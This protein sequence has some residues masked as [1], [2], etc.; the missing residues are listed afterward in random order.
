MRMTYL[1]QDSKSHFEHDD[2]SV[3]DSHLDCSHVDSTQQ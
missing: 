1:A 2:D 3:V